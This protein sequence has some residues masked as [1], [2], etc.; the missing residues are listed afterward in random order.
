MACSLRTATLEAG[1]EE[2]TEEARRAR[3][4]EEDIEAVIR[5][6][7]VADLADDA[8]ARLVRGDAARS[9]GRERARDRRA[10]IVTVR[11]KKDIQVEKKERDEQLMGKMMHE[12]IDY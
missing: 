4:E 1:E 5:E 12:R 6:R 7:D 8:L 9:V 2:V 10:A 3:A 11:S